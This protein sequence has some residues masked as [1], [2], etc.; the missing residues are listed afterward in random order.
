MPAYGV[1]EYLVVNL[2]GRRLH[3]LDLRSG[4][5]LSVDTDGV[6]RVRCFPRLWI[7]AEALLAKD[8]GRLMATSQ[9]GLATPEHADFV[10]RLAEARQTK[11]QAG[12]P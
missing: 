4:Q 3:W 2:V 11:T 8:Y 10:R 6:V 5:E 12:T 7:H 9:Q 1:L